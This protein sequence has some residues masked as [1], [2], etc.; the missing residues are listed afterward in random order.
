MVS[1]SWDENNWDMLLTPSVSSFDFISYFLHTTY[2][3][4]VFEAI[5]VA[6]YIFSLVNWAQTSVDAEKEFISAGGSVKT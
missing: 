5:L 3:N 6:V 1:D 4:C 2:F